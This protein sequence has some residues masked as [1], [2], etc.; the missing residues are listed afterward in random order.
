M[1]RLTSMSSASGLEP[2]FG[3]IRFR[4]EDSHGFSVVEVRQ[5]ERLVGDHKELLLR[6][7]HEY[8]GDAT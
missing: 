3:S 4:L 6:A 8:F 7:W 2:S 5:V 1:S